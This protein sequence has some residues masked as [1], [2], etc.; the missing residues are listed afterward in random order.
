MQHRRSRKLLAFATASVVLLAACGDDEEST[1]TTA[2]PETTAGGSETTMAGGDDMS[3]AGLC[4]DTVVIQTDWMPEAEHGFLYNLVGDGYTMDADKA[5][6]TG[7]LVAG[8]VDTGVQIQIR[9]GGLPQQFSPVTQI[10]YNNDDVLLGFVYTDEAIQF[11]GSEFPTV[12]IMSGFEKNP[13]MI[14]WDPATYPDVKGIADLGTEGV[15]VRYFGGAA[16][17]DYLTGSGI[18]S[19][20]QVDGSYT[21]DPGLFIADEGKS[22]QQ[23]FGSAEPYLYETELTDWGKPVAYEYINDIGWENYAQSIA[24]KP[25]NITTYAD[26]FTKLVPMIQQSA[27]D[28]I[29]SP[30]HGNEVILAAVDSFGG[31]FGWTYTAGA[32]DY[33]VATIKADGLQANGTDGVMGSF[34]MDRVAGL[35]E[36]A[37]PIYEAQGATPKAGVTPDD[38]VTNQFIDT[39]ISL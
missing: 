7:P 28:Y 9:S 23:G 6:V 2:A 22:A 24:T 20:D 12:A 21:G 33:G 5:Y 11:S 38:I 30:A 15:T 1:S 10:M 19:K 37:V 17:M 13:Q 16:Y 34:D 14:M 32:A 35:I 29:N 18:L 36:I 39:S 8:G 4:P 31:D 26:C 3:L 27:V 25:E